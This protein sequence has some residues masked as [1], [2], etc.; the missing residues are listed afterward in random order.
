MRRQ[1]HGEDA[2]RSLAALVV[3]ILAV[4]PAL[5]AGLPAMAPG[6]FAESRWGVPV[7][8]IFM[9]VLMAV[10]VLLASLCSNAAKGTRL[11]GTED[12]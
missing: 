8:V 7:S 1:G 9:S 4:L 6:V 3:I 2:M 12:Q 5:F 11:H 10:F